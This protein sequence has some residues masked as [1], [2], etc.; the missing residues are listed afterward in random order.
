MLL[1]LLVGVVV[2]LLVVAGWR[3][4]GHLFVEVITAA[5]VDWAAFS[6]VEKVNFVMTLGLGV[7]GLVLSIAAV[8]LSGLAVEVG[9]QANELAAKATSIAEKQDRQ[10][11]DERSKRAAFILTSPETK[12]VRSVPDLQLFEFTLWVTNTGRRASDGYL[13]LGIPKRISGKVG[14]SARDGV[15]SVP[16][17]H[18]YDVRINE[19]DNPQY[20]HFHDDYELHKF[21]ITDQ[22]AP[23]E[24]KWCL[25][26][27]IDSKR[28][29]DDNRFQRTF[30]WFTRTADER[31]PSESME[32]IL[33]AHS[34]EYFLKY[35]DPSDDGTIR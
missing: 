15:R 34:N 20:S 10:M 22:L 31:Y 4:W 16:V 32:P 8:H 5:G 9:N 6:P 33:M 2:A 27:K 26:V 1:K 35:P 18:N 23:F 12:N 17:L 13:Y 24:G 28:G 11:E 7:I 29:E 14:I 21:Q 3:L 25:T 19:F 30:L